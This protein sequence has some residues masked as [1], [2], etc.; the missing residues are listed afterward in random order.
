MPFQLGLS[1]LPGYDLH[2]FRHIRENARLHPDVPLPVGDIGHDAAAVLVHEGQAVFAVE[3]ERLSRFKHTM[4]LPR[5]ASQACAEVV[6]LSPASL[7]A[8][9][10]LDLNDDHLHRHLQA[11]GAVDPRLERAIRAEFQRTREAA[12]AFKEAFPGLEAVDHHL[13]HAAS[14]YY[15]SGFERSLVLVMD[16]NGE[17]AS[18]SLYLGE[19]PD[20][21]LLLSLPTISSLGL[22][23]AF[24]TH[25][26]GF[27]PIEDEYKVM[28]LAAYGEGDDTYLPFFEGQLQ[29][30]GN[31]RFTI[32][33][34]LKDPAS[35]TVRWSR[36][37]GAARQLEEPIE[38]RHMALAAGLQKALER[39][40]LRLIEPVEAAHHT[41]HLCLAGGVALNCSL[42]GMLDR[43]G[44]FD[45][46]FVQ[47]AA[48]DPGAALG[49]AL[50]AERRRRGGKLPERMATPYLGPAFTAADIETAL[51]AHASALAWERPEDLLDRTLDL[52]GAGQ[53]VGWFQGRMEFGPRALGN[54][55][56]LADPRRADMKD[57]V[58]RAVK[59]R[60][61]FR[62]FAPSVTAEGA[63]A[64]FHLRGLDQ[65]EHM[66]VAVKAR[67]DRA[68]EIPAVVH[69]NGTSRVQVVRR[70]A[71]PRYWELLTR[72][73]RR[74]GVPILLNT[75]FNVRGEP[76]VCSPEDAIR[77][78]LG[79]GLDAL[80]LEDTLVVKRT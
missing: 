51:Q 56:I 3:E 36:Q 70:E 6:G 30:E 79:T 10:Y 37:L 80:V 77:C 17:S 32:P 39:A 34:L 22:L 38:A 13:A 72:Q 11:T 54:R 68:P 41:R 61:E 78:F 35:R 76:I 45:R 25:F 1:G 64:F 2:A 69:V 4:G 46:L 28:G 74:T 33:A 55:S 65:Y 42:N 8:A 59:K 21:R 14:A 48:G 71:N 31:A 12:G 23:Y 19:G 62:P 16:G 53:V 15:L 20:L 49:A 57:R 47:P 7:P 29:W 24:G 26:L 50:V 27:E 18:L 67:A 66:T 60:E 52:I 40:V 75:S 5:R 73:G 58:N 44:L 63:D 43:S 9:H